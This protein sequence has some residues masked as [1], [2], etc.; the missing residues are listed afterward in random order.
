M[1]KLIYTLCWLLKCPEYFLRRSK[2]DSS[3]KVQMSAKIIRSNVAAYTY[4][5]GETYLVDAQVG[6]YCS[7][8]AGVKVG[9]MEH[10]W[11]WFSTSSFLSQHHL[12]GKTTKIEDDVWM[13]VNVVVLQGVTIGQGAVVGAGAVVLKDVKPYSIVAGVPAK[14]IRMRFDQEVIDEIIEAD[15]LKESPANAKAK[16]K[17]IEHL[18]SSEPPN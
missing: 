4:I 3:A 15:Y 9:G 14:E 17:A 5:G 16:I 6:R 7:I 12:S 1:R 11:W 2:V 18:L 13:G 10:S 8:A